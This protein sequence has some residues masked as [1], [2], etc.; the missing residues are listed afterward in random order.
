MKN[1]KETVKTG[2]NKIASEYVKTRSEETEDIGLL[3]ELINRLSE[4]ARILDAGCGAGEPVARLLSQKFDVV[5]V[6]FSESQIELARQRLPQAEFIC[7]DMT[8]LSFPEAS[9]DAIVSYYAIIHIPRKE[10]EGLLRQFNRLLKPS[11]LALLCLGANDIDEDI[12]ED[13]LGT[14]T[15]MFWSHFDSETN[16]KLIDACGFEVIWSREVVDASWPDSS[17]LFVLMQKQDK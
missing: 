13:Y 16:L 4:G 7:E 17:H 10:H 5:G 8:K 15:R 14:G 2:Y 6:D 11:G 1:H 9:F 12:D 3:D